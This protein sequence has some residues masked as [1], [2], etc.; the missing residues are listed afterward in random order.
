V[1][2]F[3]MSGSIIVDGNLGAP[4]N[5]ART[6]LAVYPNPVTDVLSI[7]SAEAITGL[8]LYDVNG[9][10]LA[11]VGNTMS[12]VKLYM[13]GYPAGIYFVEVGSAGKTQIRQIV[14]R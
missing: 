12:S 14:K 8:A 7:E 5:A 1:F 10:R 6:D 2:H 3:W 13:E 9:K 4:T 11:H